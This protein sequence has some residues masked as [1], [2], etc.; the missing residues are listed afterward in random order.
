MMVRGHGPIH[1][2]YCTGTGYTNFSGLLQLTG[3]TRKIKYLFQIL[4][5]RRV[6]NLQSYK[7]TSAVTVGP[8]TINISQVLVLLTVQFSYKS[9]SS[10]TS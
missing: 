6:V 9:T 8:R 7:S 2:I 5:R 4:D 1:Y 3:D 10:W